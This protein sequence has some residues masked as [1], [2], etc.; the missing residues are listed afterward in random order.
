MKATSKAGCVALTV[1]LTALAAAASADSQ[2]PSCFGAAARDPSH[3][4]AS[5]KQYL[6]VTPAPNEAKITPSAPCEPIRAAI[7]VCAFGA[8]RASGKA[9]IALVGDSHADQWRA[10]VDV[11]A[12]ALSW[13]GLSITRPSCPFSAGRSHLA[14]P[15][16]PECDAWARRVVGWLAGQP[17]IHTLFMS[18]H[19]SSVRAPV[20]EN[21]LT[22]QVNGYLQEWR[23]LPSSIKH[24]VV[25]RDTPYASYGTL[26]CVQ[27]ALAQRED[28]G[29][30]CELPRSYALRDDASVIAA[31]RL[32]SPR[33]SVID[34]TQYFCD[35]RFCYPVVGGAL[36]YRDAG[37]LTRLFSSTLGPFL[38]RA[39][40]RLLPSWHLR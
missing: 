17:A 36:V 3:V 1:I 11:A 20:G 9:T 6:T 40:D 14:Q 8:P 5:R 29:R 25:I 34:L 38:L 37:H 32:R 22:A 18:D 26:T 35:Q 30:A 19:R 33:V 13:Y 16:G 23:A 12:R 28:A 39:V 21:Q 15:L 31:A 7:K 2:S 10:A 4:C 27:N 24:V